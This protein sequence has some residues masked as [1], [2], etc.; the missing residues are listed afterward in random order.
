MATPGRNN[1]RRHASWFAITAIVTGIL[2]FDT[3]RWSTSTQAQSGFALRLYGSGD[4]DRDRVKIPLGLIDAEGRITASYPVNLASE[5]TIEFWMKAFAADNPAPACPSGWYTGNIIIDRDVFG[6]GDYGDYGIAICNQRLVVGI[7][8]GS[9]DRLLTGSA[10]V[11]DGVWHHI[12]VTRAA[13]GQVQL[14]VDGQ[15]DGV[16]NGPLGRIDYPLNRTT[17]YPNSDPYLVLGAEKHDYPGSR[18]YNGWLDDLRLSRVARY[19][20]AFARPAAPHPVDHETVALYRFDE[21]S[22][23][24]IGDSAPGSLSAGELRARSA[25]N[26]QHWSTD[27]PFIIGSPPTATPT[28]AAAPTATPTSAAA[29]TAT[30]TSAAAPTATRAPTNT[31]TVTATTARNPTPTLTSTITPSAVSA[32]P[33]MTP[34]PQTQIFIPMLTR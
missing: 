3:V 9:D 10:I 5:L 19:T 7:S 2:L 18:H 17:S 16:L 12:A 1:L 4:P 33:T 13:N 6:A 24:L 15:P 14:F 25:G 8:V 27:T 23:T 22:G 11:A 32:P 34:A 20:G 26:S 31:I 29:P 30:P 28:S 21:G